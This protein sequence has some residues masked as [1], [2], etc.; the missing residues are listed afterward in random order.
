VDQ[1]AAH[2]RLLFDQ[3][4]KKQ[5]STA[6]QTLLIPMVLD[7][8]PLEVHAAE[9]FTEELARLGFSF[10]WMGPS[11]IRISELPVHIPA[12]EA[13]GL[14]RQFL[15]SVLALK[16]PDAE[17]F[18]QIWIETAACHMAVRA[19]QNLNMPQMQALLDEMGQS[20]RPYT[21]PHGR[22]TTIRFS[23]NDLAR[24]FKRI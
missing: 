11:A 24:L 10:D 19:G 12:D 22:P 6:F 8:D 4:A 7:L 3:L 5:S 9:T 1:H 2:E 15:S 14:L 23:E 20:E 21:C 17:T 16:T 13:A 18:R